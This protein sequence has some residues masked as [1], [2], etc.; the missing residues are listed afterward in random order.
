MKRKL[1]T[2]ILTVFIL[3]LCL[4][5]CES[6]SSTS[7]GH[8]GIIS[9]CLND[10]GTAAV[11]ACENMTDHLKDKINAEKEKND[12]KDTN[13]HKEPGSNGSLPEG[14]P[15]PLDTL[16]SDDGS[17]LVLV[18]KLHAVSADYYPTDMVAVDGSLST[19]QGLYLKRDAYDA[20]LRM[21]K[22]AQ[23]QDLSFMICSAY[24][25]YATQKTLYY[26]Y[27]DSYGLEYT[28]TISAYPGR[29][30][31]HTG[32]AIDIT[33]KSMNYGLYQDFINYPEGR[34]INDHCSEYGFIV[35]YPADKTDITGYSYEPWHLRY[36]GVDVAREITSKGLTLEEYL[37]K[38]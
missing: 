9:A 33:S 17:R 8:A 4:G 1:L 12:M 22:D 25:S 28:N 37:D 32:W 14:I 24:R 30:E 18:N 19:N 15:V 38:A 10:F 29:S 6:G 35:R 34:W 31:H 16:S 36:V 26:N 21:L 20:Y 2:T 13:K 11:T 7:G 23:A 3:L 27:I 5:G